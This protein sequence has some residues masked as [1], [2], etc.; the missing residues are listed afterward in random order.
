M[1]TL[2]GILIAWFVLSVY[3]EVR[4]A[5]KRFRKATQ[6]AFDFQRNTDYYQL[7]DAAHEIG[8]R[9]RA[10]KRELEREKEW[11]AINEIN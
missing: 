6:N 5:S 9:E 8:I 7:W 3:H 4:G 10:K 11:I 1:I 2:I